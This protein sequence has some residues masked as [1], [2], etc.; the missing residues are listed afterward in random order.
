M[1]EKKIKKIYELLN[2]IKVTEN[3]KAVIEEIRN[4][5]L[6]QEYMEAIKKREKLNAIQEQEEIIES[7]YKSDELEG[8]ED[9]GVYPKKLSNIELERQYIGLLLSDPKLIVK[10]YFIGIYS[11]YC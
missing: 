1:D 6:N 8:N 5:L 3:N 7:I 4:L 2:G 10:Y 11:K 9:N